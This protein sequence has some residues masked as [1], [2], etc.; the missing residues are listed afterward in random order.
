M[1]GVIYTERLLIFS[2]IN[3]I[4]NEFYFSFINKLLETKLLQIYYKKII[5][6][7]IEFYQ[8][9]NFEIYNN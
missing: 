1:E 4:W 5:I 6:Y 3:F 8:N 2:Y 7:T 9:F